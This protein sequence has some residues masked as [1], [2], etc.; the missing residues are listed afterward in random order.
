MTEKPKNLIP[1]PGGSISHHIRNQVCCIL[2]TELK[3]VRF[4]IASVQ[5]QTGGVDCGLFALAF[6][7]HIL[8]TG[9]L[10]TSTYF[11][12]SAMRA[13]LRRSFELEQMLPF[14]ISS[15]RTITCKQLQRG[16]PVY[17][18]CRLVWIDSDTQPNKYVFNL[19]KN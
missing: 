11:D 15:A 5:Q 8:E 2:H 6:A 3:E 17:C 1:P 13:T 10:P 7:R 14:P 18:I 4:T 16:E 19:I 9:C 12:Q